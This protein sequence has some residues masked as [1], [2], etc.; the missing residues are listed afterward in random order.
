MVVE[1]LWQSRQLHLAVPFSSDAAICATHNHGIL[2]PHGCCCE[3]R[4]KAPYRPRLCKATKRRGKIALFSIP[5]FAVLLFK[6]Y[7]DL[8][9]RW[10]PSGIGFARNCKVAQGATLWLSCIEDLSQNL[11]D[12]MKQRR[13]EFKLK[14]L[15][16]SLTM[17]WFASLICLPCI[18]CGWIRW[19]SSMLHRPAS[20][21]QNRPLQ[22]SC[23]RSNYHLWKEN[24][25]MDR[26]EER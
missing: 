15:K 19:P 20:S 23:Q 12:R 22:A 13:V 11:N 4:A 7:R 25:T 3:F 24:R 16:M 9:G 1:A 8:R 10:M 5:A 2:V 18:K 17:F 14:T 6:Q 26:K 21:S